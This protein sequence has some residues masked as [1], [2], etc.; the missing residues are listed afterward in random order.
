MKKNGFTLIEL[1]IVFIII[2]I[3]SFF[4]YNIYF[5]TIERA[6]ETSARANLRLLHV[7]VEAYATDHEGRYPTATTLN[8]LY[9]NLKK[10]IPNGTFP[11]NPYNNKPYS[12]ENNEHYKITYTYDPSLNSYTLS[13]MDRFNQK[14]LLLLSNR[15]VLEGR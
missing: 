4:I 6:R 12:D 13:V 2:G 11:E 7:A 14:V 3:L 5:S 15:I 1:M 8:D 10:Y 9:L